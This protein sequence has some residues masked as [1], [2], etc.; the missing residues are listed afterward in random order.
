[1]LGLML[2]RSARGHSKEVDH[3]EV[4]FVEYSK[5]L[6]YSV[7]DF[8]ATYFDGFITKTEKKDLK[9][10]IVLIGGCTAENGNSWVDG[11]FSGYY[12]SEFTDKVTAFFPGTGEFQELESLPEARTRH[13][14]VSLDGKIY[15]IGGRNADDA[16]I[17]EVLVFDPEQQKWSVYL[18][19]EES[20]QTSDH[21]SVARDGKIY[22]FGGWDAFYS[23]KDKV[24]S[25]DTKDN[26]KITDLE[27]MTHTRGDIAVVHYKH[28]GIDAAYI[29]GG[30]SNEN[31]Y[32]APFPTV[33]SYDFKKDAWTASHSL[34]SERG[35][36]AAVVIDEMIFAVGG[37]GKHEDMCDK[38]P[39]ELDE[40][41]H[42]VAVDDVEILDPK[43]KDGW[44]FMTKLPQIRF[45]AS[46]AVDKKSNT[47]YLFGGQKA[48]NPDCNCYKT[49]DTIY[50][51]EGHGHGLG[52]FPIVVIV[53]ASVAVVGLGFIFLRRRRNGKAG[54]IES[55]T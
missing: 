31:E 52:A 44:K 53:L 48:Y 14:A 27:P 47:L 40:N 9:R 36:K 4:Q 7:S 29:M 10:S 38:S 51:Y 54:D 13:T 41:E 35:D 2:S 49:A 37:E 23:A 19:L 42:S 17:P 32:C 28:K 30:F 5:K 50:Y 11:E 20:Y 25:I 45:R 34:S 46:A 33:E 16:L 43:D 3:D 18:T 24:Y 26:K 15:V 39:S 21:A 12:C 55:A 1:M 8:T 22:V 6:D